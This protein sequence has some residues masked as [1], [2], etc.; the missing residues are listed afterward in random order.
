MFAKDEESLGPHASS[1]IWA[2]GAGVPSKRLKLYS[3]RVVVGGSKV[4]FPR[5]LSFG[6]R[7]L[8]LQPLDA[9]AAPLFFWG[10]PP[11]RGGA[12]TWNT[13]SA[14]SAIACTLGVATV[15]LDSRRRNAWEYYGGERP[16]SV[17]RQFYR[18]IE[19]DS[20]I[21]RVTAKRASVPRGRNSTNNG[22]FPAVVDQCQFSTWDWFAAKTCGRG[23]TGRAARFYTQHGNMPQKV[24]RAPNPDSREIL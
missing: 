4:G 1:G 2:D 8:R 9:K 7:G 6:S 10:A 19:N 16:G 22:I 13:E 5:P 3:M 15:S 17:L 20:D 14:P 18:R 11:P 12:G 23:N 24:S 21:P